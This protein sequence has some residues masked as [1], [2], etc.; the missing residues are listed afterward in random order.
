VD[1]KQS[2]HAELPCQPACLAHSASF[3]LCPLLALAAATNI[4]ILA[5]RLALHTINPSI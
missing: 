3:I 5:T 4:L 1:S 2:R